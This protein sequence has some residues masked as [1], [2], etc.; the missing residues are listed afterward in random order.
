VGWNVGCG[1]A[2][3]EVV[4]AELEGRIERCGQPAVVVGHS[5]GGLIGRVAAVRRPDLVSALVTVC[6]PWA[7]GPPDR[8]GVATVSNLVRFARR[9]GMR[10]MGSIDC[11]EGPCCEAFRSDM[12]RVPA[13]PWAALWSSRDTIGGPDSR[14][15]AGPDRTI[16]VG[17][18][19]LGAVRSA[20]GRDAIGDS[21]RAFGLTS[22]P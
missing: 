20:A 7:I 12:T 3:V 18:S 14:P 1:D 8:P 2:T 22:D 6:T 4:L 15:P 17:T 21:L 5:R 13:G 10:T 19:H 11:A 9:H 16:D